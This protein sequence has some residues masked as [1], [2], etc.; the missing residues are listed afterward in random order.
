MLNKK[1]RGALE[2]AA[3]ME[4]P[5]SGIVLELSTTEPGMQVYSANNVKPG[6]LDGNGQEIPLRGGLALETQHFPDSPNRP[7]FP[8]TA[9]APGDTFRSTTIFRFSVR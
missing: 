6:Q 5:Q 9:L 2:L 3:R 1:K 8:S 4:D 7:A